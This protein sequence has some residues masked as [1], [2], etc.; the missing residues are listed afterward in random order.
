MS[1][2]TS[3]HETQ[4]VD[5]PHRYTR[6]QRQA[7]GRIR[8]EQKRF[9][10]R[11]RHAEIRRL[12]AEGCSQAQISR[13]VHYHPSTVSR[14]LRGIIRTC[15]TAAETTAKI[16]AYPLEKLRQPGLLRKLTPCPVSK[17]PSPTIRRKKRPWNYFR[18][19]WGSYF[20]SKFKQ[21]EVSEV[22][23]VSDD[24]FSLAD[25]HQ[26]QEIDAAA[27]GFG[28]CKCGMAHYN[29]VQCCAM[30][31][32]EPRAVTDKADRLA[33][34]LLVLTRS[35]PGSR[36]PLWAGGRCFVQQDDSRPISR[37]FPEK[38]CMSL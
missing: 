10:A 33:E 8:G 9:E 7:G 18:G 23:E 35:C 15:L 16:I 5:N 31:G 32:R 2:L 1:S 29:P 6:E 12:Y 17:G 22:S 13:R 26:R 4:I 20:R 19:K 36:K 37:T 25:W 27:W 38:V 21:R 24:T 34:R 14:V 28:I 11:P 30:C 3:L